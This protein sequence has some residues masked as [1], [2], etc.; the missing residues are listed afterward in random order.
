MPS[1][2]RIT[3]SYGDSILRESDLTILNSKAWLN[4]RII[5]FAFE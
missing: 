5:G 4:D 1:K 3:L 2:D